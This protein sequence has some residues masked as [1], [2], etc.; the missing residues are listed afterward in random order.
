MLEDIF[1]KL[2]LSKTSVKVYLAL[3]ELGA[4]SAG[5]LAKKINIPR[6]TLYGQLYELVNAGIVNLAEE[7]GIKRWIA[8]SPRKINALI[9]AKVQEW[10][11]AQ[12]SFSKIVQELESCQA[13]DFIKPHFSYFEGTKGVRNI[14]EDVLL[15]YDINTQC[16]WPAR[17][18]MEMLGYDYM[19]W[20]NVRR[21]RQNIYLQSIWPQ[22]KS[23]D[24]SKNPFLGVGKEFKREIRQAP[25]GISCSMGYWAYANKVGFISS[26]KE[27]FGFIVESVELRE[28]LKTQFDVLWHMSQPIKVDPKVMLK[29]LKDNKLE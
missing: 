14:L 16:F 27:S 13:T 24:I 1:A 9:N 4:T 12:Q 15:Y 10:E 23:V 18:M 26:R 21:I 8:Q 28:M 11:E 7:D 2:N 17:D 3:L 29:F 6:A 20:H 5:F 22:E 19:N 25:K